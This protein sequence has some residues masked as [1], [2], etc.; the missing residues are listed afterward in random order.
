M[1]KKWAKIVPLEFA[2]LL[3]QFELVLIHKWNSDWFI[4]L[5]PFTDRLRS[6]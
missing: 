3:M 1:T 4:V 6:A 5:E 2:K